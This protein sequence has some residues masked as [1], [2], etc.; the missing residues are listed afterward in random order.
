MKQT[1]EKAS[2]LAPKECENWAIQQ[3]N[4]A[5]GMSVEYFSIVDAETMLP[6]KKWHEG[7][8]VIACVAAFSVG[9]RLI[10]NMM[11]FS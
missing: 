7:Q 9:V 5:P 6:V 3:I 8:Q 4:A 2:E 10:D 1:A 11:L